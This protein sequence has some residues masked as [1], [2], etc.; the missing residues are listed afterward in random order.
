MATQVISFEGEFTSGTGDELTTLFV[1]Q[2]SAD[3][4]TERG[5]SY[6]IASKGYRY[7]FNGKENDNEIK[8]VGNQQ[9]YGMRVYDPRVGKF[10]SVDPLTPKYPDLTPYQFASNMPIWAIDLDGLE[11]FKVTQRS[12]APWARFGDAFG[13]FK[14]S[15]KGDN[16][17]G[18]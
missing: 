3:P 7:G 5:I 11:S 16:R 8:G 15:F 17:G 10:L 13:T 6:G 2:T 9:D 4:G 12:F 14:K 1:D 18:L